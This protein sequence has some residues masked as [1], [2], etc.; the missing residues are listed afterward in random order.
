M[1]LSELVNEIPYISEP[2]T[3]DIDITGIVSDSRSV[4]PGYLFVALTGQTTDGHRF[5]AD[6][7]E[8]GAAAVV[9]TRPVTILKVPYLQV[10]NSHQA[11]PHLAAAFYGYPGRKLTVVGVTGT[12]GK[13]TTTNLIHSIL[14][15][16]GYKAGMISTINA[17]IGDETLDTGFHVTTPD[18]PD[19]QRYL[20]RMVDAGLTHAVLEVTSHGLA[21][22][23]A[24]ACE[25]D[26]A[27]V[28]NITHEHL[29]YHG[30]FEDYRSAKARL[31]AGLEWTSPKMQGN[32]RKAVLNRDDSSF[33]YLSQKAT[34][35]RI[36]YGFHPE[37]DIRPEGVEHTLN[38]L[39]FVV[40]GQGIGFPINCPLVGDFNI[41][42]CLAA[43]TATVY[44]LGISLEAAQIAI[45]SFNGVP[46]R[47]ERI[48]LG[49]DYTAMVDFA[50][51]P[52][53]L[54]QALVTA[55]QLTQG[56][57]I[58]VFGAAGLRDRQK[59]MLMAGTSLELA[60]LTILT[61]EDPR[62]ESLNDILVEMAAGAVQK[63]GLEGQSFWRI[64]DRGEAI[65]F[66]I[67]QA[68]PGDLVI[69]CGKGHEQS[70]CFGEVEYPWDDRTAMKAAISEHLGISGP[71]MPYLPTQ[72]R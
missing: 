71:E 1:K 50:H 12:D 40:S 5:I 31:F 21:Q 2:L 20:S 49:Q 3:G 41:S 24:D 30:S 8:R 57:V 11:L 39:S 42:N 18:A 62:T 34:G 19:V 65:K 13:T 51:T 27:V 37:A 46:G 10:K 66:A 38:G 59:R 70:M 9:G 69:S 52:N 44:S 53:A 14:Q 47:M 64:P 28:T 26:V 29:D 63:G 6:A 58:A 33:A 32:P 4:E 25:F 45:S 36:S 48:N 54:H 15:A 60:D 43:I 7:L 61:A 35:E 22:Y 16:A 17:V 56:R 23:R 55:R 67:S 68:R 72:E